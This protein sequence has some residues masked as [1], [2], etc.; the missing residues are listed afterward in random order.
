VCVQ[1]TISLTSRNLIA[2]LFSVV[3]FFQLTFSTVET[4]GHKRRNFAFFPVKC[5]LSVVASAAELV[6][7]PA[8]A[9]D[10]TVMYY[11]IMY[12]I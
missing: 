3:Y 10:A 8:A 2:F 1:C 6:Q 9:I 12:Y 11:I 5:L 7:P 4:S